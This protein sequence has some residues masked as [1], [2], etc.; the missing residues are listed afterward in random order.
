MTKTRMER[1]VEARIDQMERSISSIEEVIASLKL[2][3][4]QR[5]QSIQ[6]KQEQRFA[7]LE[8][9]LTTLVRGKVPVNE[10]EAST[11]SPVEGTHS[12]VCPLQQTMVMHDPSRLLNGLNYQISI[13]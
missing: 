5:L 4:D 1:G 7:H 8:T 10:A 13:A 6:T 2:E 3:Q 9:L 12:I 11:K